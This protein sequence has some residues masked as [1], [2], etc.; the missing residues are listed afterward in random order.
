M[1]YATNAHGKRGA[2]I[3]S[4]V[5]LP[6]GAVDVS[7]ELVRDAGRKN[8]ASPTGAGKLYFGRDVGESQLQ[9]G[10]W[11]GASGVSLASARHSSRRSV[12]HF[13]RLEF[14]GTL[15]HRFAAQSGPN[16]R[17]AATEPALMGPLERARRA[18]A[19]FRVALFGAGE[20]TCPAAY[21][22]RMA[23]SRGGDRSLIVYLFRLG[24]S[25]LTGRRQVGSW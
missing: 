10:N 9:M 22:C 19:P 8:C 24:L 17:G 21:T 12:M 25:R 16:S 20:A 6:R 4:R 3:T 7:Y 2:L 1:V 18:P 23:F 15:P 13:G 5:P 11:R 14:S